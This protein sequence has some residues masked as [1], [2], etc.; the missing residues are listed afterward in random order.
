MLRIYI[1][2]FNHSCFPIIMMNSF[3]ALHEY[4]LKIWLHRR[5]LYK[6]LA[7]CGHVF[8]VSYLLKKWH[9]HTWQET[10]V[11]TNCTS[12]LPLSYGSTALCHGGGVYVRCSRVVYHFGEN[13]PTKFCR[14]TNRIPWYHRNPLY[15]HIIL[16]AL[17]AWGR[18]VPKLGHQLKY[19][20]KYATINVVLFSSHTQN[21]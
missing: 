12:P 8:T 21:K 2:R 4:D 14:C 5:D 7:F 3:S 6:T 10:N 1:R 15:T 17:T 13:A 20:E 19:H 11:V 16:F 18:V 9:L